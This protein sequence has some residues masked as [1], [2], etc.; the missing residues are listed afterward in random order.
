MKFFM[1]R[2]SPHFGNCPPWDV[3]LSLQTL[4]TLAPF[5]AILPLYR[6]MRQTISSGQLPK[7]L[8]LQDVIPSLLS[9][10]LLLPKTPCD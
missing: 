2:L 9:L 5:E 4:P 10:S 7:K 6:G 3:F 8:I 1:M